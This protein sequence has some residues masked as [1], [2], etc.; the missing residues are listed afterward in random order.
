M[1]RCSDHVK[2][3]L[4][5]LLWDDH[6]ERVA[7]MI[8][9]IEGNDYIVRDVLPARNEDYRPSEEF[10]ISGGQMAQLAREAQRRGFIL[11]GVAHSHLPHHPSV[12]SE[13]DIH[14]CRHAVNA[15][16][17]PASSTLSWFD[18]TGELRRERLPVP[19]PAAAGFP[20]LAFV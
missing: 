2:H 7:G 5:D 1:I 4:T 16:F 11:L 8:G 9:T 17:H 19:A 20:V 14:Y 13:A 10:Y 18:S 3:K 15:M 6:I 12:P